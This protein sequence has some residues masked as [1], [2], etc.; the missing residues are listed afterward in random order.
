MFWAHSDPDGRSW[1]SPESRWQ[2]LADHLRN[3]ASLARALA[4]AAAP[5][6]PALHHMA[7]MAGLLHDYGKY[8]E[9]FQ[10]MIREGRGRCPHSIHGAIAARQFRLPRGEPSHNW[11]M[12]VVRAIAAHHAGLLDDAE[13]R[14]K[15]NA[16]LRSKARP[17]RQAPDP[18]GYAATAEKIRPIAFRD[19]PAIERI[20]DA[21]APPS[22]HC[23]QDLLTRILLSC[24]VDADRLDTARRTNVQAPLRASERLEQLLLHLNDLH[25]Q[26]VARGGNKTVLDTRDQV[27]ELCRM[28]S[29]TSARL[30]SLAVPT[31]GGKTLAT[32]RFS[33]E[34]AAARPEETRRIIVVIPYLSIIEQ[35]AEVYRKIFGDDAIFEHHSGAV[36][37]LSPKDV[38]GENIGQFEPRK[39]SD[40][41]ANLPLKRL[42]TE[43]WDAPVIVT[44]S[45]RLF[46]SLFS[47]H[48]SDLRR[49]HNIARSIIVLDE[50]QTLPRRL[51]SPLLGMLRE[52]TE[53]WGCTVVMATATQP[54][55]EARLPKHESYAWP[56]G[57][58]TPIIPPEVATQ[59]HS[60][61][62][63]VHIEW[64]IDRPT[65]WDE[66]S[67]EMLTQPQALC[68]VNLRQHAAR[69]YDTLRLNAD[70]IQR[71]GIFHLSTRMCAQHRLDVLAV[72]RDRLKK[73][74]PCLVVSTQLIEAGVD[75]DFPIAFRALGPLDAIIQVAG[76]VDREGRLT[77]ATGEPAGRLIVFESEDGKTP[78][79]EYK[80]A[81]AVTAGLAREGNVQT[82]DL[83][84]MQ[85]YF[86]RYYGDADEQTR[87]EHLARMRDDNELAF[88]TL[89]DQFE[90]INSRTK[91]VFVAYKEGKELIRQLE[92]AHHLDVQLLRKLQ[93]YSVGLQPWEFEEARKK[94]I[95]EVFPGSDVW[96]CS[97][98]AYEQ[99]GRGLL[100]E[101]A[102]EGLIV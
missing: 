76:R 82:D 47:N 102:V 54:A 28:A 24:L 56:K 46:E 96:V 94:T 70:E 66:L 8:T 11:A 34:R 1:D 69:L 93:R 55:F 22:A 49:I 89:A 74:L 80:E 44:T 90:M 20:L 19:E 43:N 26:A 53:H 98:A 68:V 45:V 60:D 15:T 38:H 32:M 40:T 87:G 101:Q 91:D 9:C 100:T 86:E 81:T 29:H 73:G 88:A 62:R 3:V 30:L 83:A 71:E 7:S 92:K 10:K 77:A 95:Y 50:V 78:P 12:P 25:A 14:S 64:R 16:G 79:Y 51:L 75:V 21:S 52:L 42:E 67:A 58:V 57:T 23:S 13:L 61:L 37:A 4:Q 31:G 48:P 18:D 59:M 99:Y 85:S 6:D 27:Q 36:Y 2:P 33:L 72:I 5:G 39:E 17:G 35:N 97:N 65:S 84:A 63:R 41:D